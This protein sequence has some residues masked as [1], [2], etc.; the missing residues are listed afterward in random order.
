MIRSFCDLYLIKISILLDIILFV[1]VFVFV[2]E[3]TIKVE[4]MKVHPMAMKRNIA[5]RDTMDS[6]Q[7]SSSEIAAEGSA[8]K[9]LRRLPHV[10]GKVLQLPFRSDAD[11][12]VEENSDC[13]RFVA[14]TSDAIGDDVKLHAVEIHPGVTKIVVR[15][16]DGISREGGG[17][18]VELLLEELEVDVWRFRL[19]AMTRPELASAVFVDGELIVTVPKSEELAGGEA[20]GGLGRPVLVQ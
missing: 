8:H 6:S 9:R 3:S 7:N 19:P 2:F 18:V 14:E 4:V 20:F 16:G 5:I 10:F 1:F 13:F 12:S 17:E 11:V 15:N